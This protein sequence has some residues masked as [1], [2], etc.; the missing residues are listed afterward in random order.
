[1]CPTL[2]DPIDGS[3]QAPP[4]LGFPRQEYWHFA[5]HP[6]NYVAHPG[7]ERGREKGWGWRWGSGRQRGQ[8][9]K[10]E[11]RREKIK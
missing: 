3:P 4:F 1:L 6:P 7:R 9:G 11:M 8:G 10:I 2:W 5:L